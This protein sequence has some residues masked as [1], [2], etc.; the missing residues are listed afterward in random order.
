LKGEELVIAPEKKGFNKYKII[1][2]ITEFYVTRKNG[3]E[4]IK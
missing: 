2:D 3:I 1:G 4:V